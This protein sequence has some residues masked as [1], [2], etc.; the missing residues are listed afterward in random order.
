ME[1]GVVSRMQPVVQEEI[2]IRAGTL[3][4]VVLSGAC[5]GTGKVL[6]R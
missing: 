1:A 3:K 5:G 4:A 2:Q 6:Q